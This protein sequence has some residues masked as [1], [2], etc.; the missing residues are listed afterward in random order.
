MGRILSGRHRGMY[1]ADPDSAGDNGRHHRLHIMQ[2]LKHAGDDM[3]TILRMSPDEGL[4]RE[5]RSQI[6]RI[7]ESDGG[8]LEGGTGGGDA[9]R[10]PGSPPEEAAGD[11][12][13]GDPSGAA[14]VDGD[15]DGDTRAYRDELEDE[16][17]G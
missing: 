17:W 8:R 10:G 13:A 11:A 9:T 12:A 14:G 3:I 5:V 2:D 16:L 7:V 4:K 1:V 6:A 15:G